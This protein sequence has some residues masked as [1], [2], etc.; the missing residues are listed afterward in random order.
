MS[1]EPTRRER[2]HDALRRLQ[3][4]LGTDT[5]PDL[6]FADELVYVDVEKRL[7]DLR[8]ASWTFPDDRVEFDPESF[9]GVVY[10]PAEFDA[11]VLVFGMGVFACADAPR[12]VATDAIRHTVDELTGRFVSPQELDVSVIP[13]VE[14]D[15]G[16]WDATTY[17]AGNTSVSP[18]WC[19]SCDRPLR[20]TENYCPDC[21]AELG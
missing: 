11:T 4:R 12:D 5:L 9:R 7:D 8:R 6:D 16:A 18:G 2:A 15:H 3:I 20:G 10:R 17:A 13:L 1:D 21:G 14:G 19:P